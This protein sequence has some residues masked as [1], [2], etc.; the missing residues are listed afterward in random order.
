MKEVEYEFVDLVEEFSLDKQVL[1]M[2]LYHFPANGRR[3]TFSVCC[4][5]VPVWDHTTG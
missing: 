3:E 1:V 2:E 5:T 4:E